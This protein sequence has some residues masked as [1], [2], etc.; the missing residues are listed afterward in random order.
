MGQIGIALRCLIESYEIDNIGKEDWIDSSVCSVGKDPHQCAQSYNI[1]G[2]HLRYRA[3][4][5][6]TVS[7]RWVRKRQWCVSRVI[8][9]HFLDYHNA[10]SLFFTLLVERRPWTFFEDIL[11]AFLG[12]PA[13]ISI[14][15]HLTTKAFLN[16]LSSARYSL[17]CSCFM[18]RGRTRSC[19]SLCEI[20][21]QSKWITIQW[22]EYCKWNY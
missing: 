22:W 3:C 16:Q 8:W 5:L 19:W 2:G 13:G 4:A 10:W 17:F 11:L 15:A 21:T 6:S 9:I 1:D 12:N 14:A 20:F 7:A 18:L